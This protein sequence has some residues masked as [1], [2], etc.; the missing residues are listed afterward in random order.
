MTEVAEIVGSPEEPT[1]YEFD[2]N[3]QTKI[4]ALSLRDAN[5][6]ERTEGLIKPDYFENTPQAILVNIGQQYFAKYKR[7]PDIVTLMSL[8]KEAITGKVIR[9]DMV[10]DVKVVIKTLLTHDISDREYV[11]DKVSTFARHQALERAVLDGSSYISKGEFE[12]FGEAVRKAMEVGA[13]ND[14]VEYDYFAEIE[15]RTNVRLEKLAGIIKP[16]G[17]STGV[18]ALDDRLYQKGW[19]KKEL[20]ILMGGAKA[21]KSTA[22]LNFCRNGLLLG[23]NVLYVTLEL[24]REIATDRLDAAFADFEMKALKEKVHDIKEKLLEL[25]KRCGRFQMHEFPSGTMRPS[26]LKR[27]ITRYKAKGIV[28]DLLVVDYLDIM[29]PEYRYND[30]I[31]NSKSIWVDVRAIAQ[32]ED[33]A[34][35]SATQT[36]RDGFKASVAKAEHVAEDFNK[37]RTADLVISINST[38][39]ERARGEARLYFAAS[40]NQEGGI[41]MFIKQDLPK[42]KFITKVLR[43]E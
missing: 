22:L 35:L 40:R 36:N 18:P 41:S 6:L 5:F 13:A 3:F 37:I 10:D 26:D 15:S 9:K 14:N 19:G 24:S 28:F 25:K 12:K 4:A 33:I 29:Q 16:T 39:E 11:V 7:S 42:M 8:V 43:I 1:K 38:D 34:I 32:T 30:E 2:L 31:A 20:S 23:H 17:V 27:L 21:G